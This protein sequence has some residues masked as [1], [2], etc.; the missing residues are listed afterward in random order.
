MERSDRRKINK[1]ATNLF[2]RIRRG[3]NQYSR[4]KFITV[5]PLGKEVDHLELLSNFREKIKRYK[6]IEEYFLVAEKE[7]TNHFHGVIIS[8]NECSY[9]AL[10]NKNNKFHFHISECPDLG[11]WC[12]YICKGLPR[13]I[14]TKDGY[15][16]F[17]KHFTYDN[18]LKDWNH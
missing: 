6:C 1:Y 8:K 12:N 13:Y 2:M 17:R 16:T 3:N 14:Y 4:C 11:T 15:E 5:T 10:F 7:N 18:N 9:K